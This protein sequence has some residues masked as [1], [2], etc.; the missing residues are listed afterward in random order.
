MSHAAKQIRDW[1]I[2]SL[3]AVAGLP[4]PTEGEP[5]QIPD[6]TDA[7]FVRTTNESVELITLTLS[8][9]ATERA[10]TVEVGLVAGTYTEVDALSVFAEE[11][12]E[13]AAGF[14]G[15]GFVLQSRSYDRNIETNRDYV[16]LTLTYEASYYVEL[17]DVETFQ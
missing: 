13:L 3:D 11:G 1:F 6:D 12:L 8:Q 14:P 4:T 16:G 2:T 9:A 7:C 5:R 10:L 15:K 17:A